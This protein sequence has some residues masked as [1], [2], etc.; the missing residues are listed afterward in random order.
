MESNTPK[1]QDGKDIQSYNIAGKLS[2]VGRSI[3]VHV[4]HEM[5]NGHDIQRFLCLSQC[6]QSAMSDDFFKWGIAP[7]L[8]NS[9]SFNSVPVGLTDLVCYFCCISPLF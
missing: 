3:L 6:V 1:K 2:G 5:D 4:I 9:Y 7:A 8:T